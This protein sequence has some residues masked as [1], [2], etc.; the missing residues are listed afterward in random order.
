[1]PPV[2]KSEDQIQLLIEVTKTN[3]EVTKNFTEITAKQNT[4]LSEVN[5]NIKKLVDY[6]DGKEGLTKTIVEE[7]K[8]VSEVIGKK[9]D[10]FTWKTGFIIT[11]ITTILG[12][13]ILFFSNPVT[14]EL[15]EEVKNLR[16]V[17]QEYHPN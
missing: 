15:K 9:F 4:L 5:T 7:R 16:E 2:E 14:N 12:A 10:S 8:N 11:L 6:L 17:I 13:L 1:M 3:I